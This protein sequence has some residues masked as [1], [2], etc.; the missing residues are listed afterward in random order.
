MLKV[1]LTGASGYVG[2]R[3]VNAL[4]ERGHSVRCLVRDPARVKTRFPKGVEIVQGDAL[5]PST[6]EKALKDIHTAYY[7]IHSMGDSKEFEE[8]DRRAAKNFA[9]SCNSAGV[10]R[11]IYLG[12]LG[13][14]ESKLSSHLRSRQEVGQVLKAFKGQ[15]IEFRASII[16]GSG[17]L[18]FEM[19]R[20]LTERLPIMVTPRWVRVKSQPIG[21]Q[22]LLSYLTEALTLTTAESL[23]IEIGGKDI[24]S[25]GDLMGEYAKQR[26]LK[27]LYL[28]VPFLSPKLSS[29]WLRL[30][31]PL[32]ARIGHKLITSIKNETIVH[33]EKAKTLFSIRPIGIS[34]AIG[35]A[36]SKEDYDFG[37]THWSD[38]L[39]SLGKQKSWAG[40]RFGTPDSGQ[41]NAN[42]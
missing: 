19:V 26:G 9:E 23:T 24:V 40:V 17:S 13:E 16:I 15:V 32:Y 41:P 29:L 33:D 27:R 38:A 4:T 22:D 34:E 20:A 5:E 1:L 10:K 2:G 25:Y 11:I 3:L 36:L 35:R 37:N 42:H 14:S 7:L 18:S 12:G 39:S 21:I 6:L 8:T 30:V 31:T 28:P